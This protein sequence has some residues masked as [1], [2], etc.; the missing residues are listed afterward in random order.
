MAAQCMDKEEFLL[1]EPHQW[2]AFIAPLI[3]FIFN[4]QNHFFLLVFSLHIGY[5]KISHYQFSY[6]S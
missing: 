4:Q 3:L 1:A 2:E 5:K 6:N